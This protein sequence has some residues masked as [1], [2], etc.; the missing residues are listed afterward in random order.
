MTQLREPKRR[1]VLLIPQMRHGGAERAASRLYGLLGEDFEVSLVVFDAR[2]AG[3]GMGE[4]IT[5]LGFPPRPRAFLIA[6]AARSVARAWALR[7]FNR[8]NNT[9]VTYSFGD[10]ANLVNVLAVGKDKKIVSLRG[11]R[12]LRTEDSLSNLL[13]FR[14]CLRF[15]LR[16]AD[17]VVTVSEGM[18]AKLKE[19]YRIPSAN[20][21]AIT[22]GVDVEALQLLAAAEDGVIFAKERP[23]I[24]AVGTFRR[25]K[26][27][28]HLLRAFA[29]SEA[30]RDAD[31]VICG[32]DPLHNAGRLQRL[33]EELGVGERTK[34]VP[35][36]DN[37]FPLMKG[38][39]VFV[40]SSESEGFPNVLVEAMALGVPV[41]ST[42][43]PTGPREVLAGGLK[44][45]S[46]EVLPGVLVEAPAYPE[47]FESD[48]TDTSIDSL[49][50]ALSAVLSSP[51]SRRDLSKEAVKRA[52][53]YSFS[54]WK[55]KHLDLMGSILSR[56]AASLARKRYKKVT[57]TWLGIST[58]FANTGW[59]M[60][61]R[62]VRNPFARA[63]LFRQRGAK[64]GEGTAIHRGV[65]LGPEPYLVTIGQN[66]QIASDVT[67]LTRSVTRII[68]QEDAFENADTFAPVIVGDD[69][70]IGLGSILLPGT[71]IGNGTVIGAGSIVTSNV[72]PRV[73]AA[74]T[75][76]RPV[77]PV[78]NLREL[79]REE[80]VM[81]RRLKSWEK[82]AALERYFAR[83]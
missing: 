10:S 78:A 73:V 17:A 83:G 34:L 19:H 6:R 14:P 70:R 26:R 56:E 52:R 15:I 12:R 38:A 58:F 41:V 67:V 49:S 24:L 11:H 13:V 81:T 7:R 44:H 42:D 3:Y 33:A 65:S 48:V 76:C 72:P 57:P 77:G 82:R 54:A 28:D 45:A 75:P 32:S 23:Y 16:S 63:E 80:A 20:I 31:L 47:T 53:D 22:N 68:P 71:T 29:L 2:D 74:G 35:F 4:H 30:S 9:D 46:G 51:A 62:L 18:A 64:I 60:R 27:F 37:P 79:L 59:K 39:A 40:L 69:V 55:R 8:K 1:I 21:S 61:T 43:C 5:E 50:N 66:C 36:Q 25:E